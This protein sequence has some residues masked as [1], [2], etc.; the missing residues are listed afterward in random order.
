MCV[1]HFLSL[2]FCL[3][4]APLQNLGENSLQDP[5]C[6]KSWAQ[7]LCVLCQIATV[8]CP[9]SY[10]TAGAPSLITKSNRHSFCIALALS[11]LAAP[12]AGVEPSALCPSA[13]RP[14]PRATFPAG[15]C[16]H[17]ACSEHSCLAKGSSRCEAQAQLRLAAAFSILLTHGQLRAAVLIEQKEG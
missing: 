13:C 14:A 17:A 12:P 9:G 8:S 15:E 7:G 4:P 5:L 1:R 16:H 10:P 11:R 2:L 6:C 3:S